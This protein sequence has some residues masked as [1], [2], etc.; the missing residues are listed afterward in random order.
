[1][2]LSHF[3]QEMIVKSFKQVFGDGDLYLFGSRVDDTEKGG[4]IDLYLV[5]SNRAENEHKLKIEFL[6]KLK[7]YIGEQKIDVIL[8]SDENRTIEKTALRDGI[9][10]N[11]SD[12]RI[13][14]YLKECDKHVKRIIESFNEVHEKFPLSAKK[15]SEL[16]DYDIKNIDQYLFRFSKLQDT[17]GN[18]LFKA[19]VGNYVEN[20]E[21]LTFLDILNKLEKIGIIDSAEEWN[22]LRTIRNDISHQYD[23]SP[24]QMA[25]ALNNILAQ[26]DVIIEIYHNLKEYYQK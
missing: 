20:I 10:L 26:K 9:K 7:K 25:E 14:K 12:I 5:P 24:A 13:D 23:D 1:M 2:R 17:I 4:D 15:Y 18:K 3:E 22:L 19:V 21:E 11:I 16:S 6:V 8:A